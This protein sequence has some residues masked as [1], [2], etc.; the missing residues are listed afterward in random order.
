MTKNGSK[1][2]DTSATDS[3]AAAV[4]LTIP[5]AAAE[6]GLPER[7]VKRLVDERRITVYKLDR[8]R[9]DRASLDAFIEN[10]RRDAVVT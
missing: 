4:G 1:A 5:E 2:S 3:G 9:V 6:Y 8:V 7:Y 10:A